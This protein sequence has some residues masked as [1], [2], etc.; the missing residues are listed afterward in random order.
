MTNNIVAPKHEKKP[1]R[2]A[3][4]VVKSLTA[5]CSAAWLVAATVDQ[6]AA[7]SINIVTLIRSGTLL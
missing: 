1:H 6:I 3:G 4:T 2:R 7:S 5:L